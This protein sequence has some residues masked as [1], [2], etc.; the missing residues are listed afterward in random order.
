MFSE[1]CDGQ[2]SREPDD[3]HQPGRLSGTVA[4]PPQ[5]PAPQGELLTQVHVRLLTLLPG[6]DALDNS[7]DKVLASYVT[8]DMW[9]S[10]K[11][12]KRH[13]K[14]TKE[15]DTVNKAQGRK[16]RGRDRGNRRVI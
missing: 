7:T 10:L 4:L 15:Q 11:T 14:I 3:S 13:F 9:Y 1:R 16:G 6:I 12:G 2:R 5:H 8:C